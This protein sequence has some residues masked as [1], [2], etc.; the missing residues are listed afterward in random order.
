MARYSPTGEETIAAG[1]AAATLEGRGYHV[2]RQPVSAGRFNVYA[3][4]AT[5]PVVVFAT[6]LDVVPPDVAFREDDEWLHGRGACD[7]KGIAGAMVAA[8][9]RLRAAGEDRIGVLLTVGEETTS[10]GAKAA[11]TLGPKGRFLIN[12]EPTENK[13]SIGQKGAFGIRLVARG[14]AAHSA[15][16]EEGVSAIELLLRTLDRI[17]ALALPTDPFLGATTL[18]IGRIEG[19]V[20]ANVIAGEA[21]ADLLFR[22][23]SSTELIRAAI[24]RALAPGVT[25]TVTLDS[26]AVRSPALPGWDTTVVRYGSDLPHLTS[27]GTGYQLGPGTI[28]L[29][30]TDEERIRKADLHRA[31]ELYVAL[32]R[33]LIAQTESQAA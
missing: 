30:H 4:G 12:G 29:A 8:A 15:Y 23:V 7:A 33:Q 27:W 25:A 18:N 17:R 14:R 22:T 26:P 28:K 31:V 32:A 13:L 5:E 1:F 2:E 20:A 6:H 3:R 10:D 9:D 24:D 11:A 19:G 21:S 16:P